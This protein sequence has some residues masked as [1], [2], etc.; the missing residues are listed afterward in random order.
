M[1]AA[2]SVSC[3]TDPEMRRPRVISAGL[4]DEIN[5]ASDRRDMEVDLAAVDEKRTVGVHRLVF[6][7]PDS[8]RLDLSTSAAPSLVPRCQLREVRVDR[9]SHAGRGALIGLGF[10]SL[11]VASALTSREA[12]DGQ[13]GYALGIP[14]L[15]GLGAATGALLGWALPK[16]PIVYPIQ[17]PDRIDPD[18]DCR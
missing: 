2:I 12:R 10:G 17:Q 14:L 13:T 5:E 4:I 8:V 15:L 11:A 9:G 16:G 3:A 7:G 6:V 1:A 18:E